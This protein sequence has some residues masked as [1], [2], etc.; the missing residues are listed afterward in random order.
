MECWAKETSVIA[1]VVEMRKRLEEISEL[2]KNVERT[3]QKQK[4]AS[5]QQAKPMSLEVGDDV[6]VLLPMQRNDSSW[7][8]LASTLLHRR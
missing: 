6:L 1:D 7:S 5:D 2:E 3:Q 8:G 4:A